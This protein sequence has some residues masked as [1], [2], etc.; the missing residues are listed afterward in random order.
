MSVEETSCQRQE[1]N[2]QEVASTE[3]FLGLII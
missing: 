2:Q 1:S 3:L